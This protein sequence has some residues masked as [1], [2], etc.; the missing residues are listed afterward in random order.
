[1]SNTNR[2][3]R[4]YGRAKSKKNLKES[5]G[6]FMEPDKRT[7]SAI[8]VSGR[9][10]VGKTQLIEE[11]LKEDPYHVPFIIYEVPDKQ[12][13]EYKDYTIDHA[14]SDLQKLTE[15]AGFTDIMDQLPLPLDH[16]YYTVWSK[17]EDFLFI[18][19]QKKV[20]LVFDEYHQSVPL[21]LSIPVIK[22]INRVRKEFDIAFPGK[23]ILTGSHQQKFD[24]LFERDAAL[25]GRIT[26]GVRLEQWSL[27]TTMEMASEQGLLA[28]PNQFLTLWTAYGGMPSHWKRYC[29]GERYR[30]LHTMNNMNEWRQALL[31]IEGENLVSVKGERYDDRAYIELQDIHRR[32]LLW[33]AENHFVKGARVRDIAKAQPFQN[34]TDKKELGDENAI[35]QKMLFFCDRLN[36]M[37]L[38]KSLD[39]RDVDRWQISDNNTL[40]QLHV[41]KEI[42]ASEKINTPIDVSKLTRNPQGK[43]ITLRRLET[44]EGHA[45]ERLAA[46]YYE[47]C[48]SIR[49]VQSS[50]D[51]RGFNGDI[52]VMAIGWENDRPNLYLGDAKRNAEIYTPEKI[53]EVSKM[54]DEFMKA[55]P[56]NKD[57]ETLR[58]IECYR[59]LVAAHFDTVTRDRIQENSEFFVLDIPDMAREYGFD[60]GPVL[61]SDLVTKDT[62]EDYPEKDNEPAEPKSPLP[63]MGM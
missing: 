47:T 24:K 56:K 31:D 51:Q 60:P 28:S 63:R 14:F 46:Q 41:F 61:V 18:L 49:W 26:S 55:L 25:H 38:K 20:V 33:I 35:R 4:F 29:T 13:K 32:I 40:F 7:F 42:L 22:A 5:L 8:S 11:V 17:C 45:L 53:E 1:M 36:L 2:P 57:M 15:Q 58:Q 62:S 21:G 50:V 52:D 23:I 39:G 9:R 48:R 19:M 3:W 44:L 27:R 16:P 37:G 30:H 54:Q 12:K 6:F 10:W 59:F 43:S 34:E